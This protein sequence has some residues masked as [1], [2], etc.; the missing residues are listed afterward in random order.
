MESEVHL[1]GTLVAS[2]IALICDNRRTKNSEIKVVP[3]IQPKK[4]IY[5]NTIGLTIY[6]K[7]GFVNLNW[8]IRNTP[9]NMGML[10]QAFNS[11]TREAEAVADGSL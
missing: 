10:A 1:Q 6:P 2:V 9:L 5:L 4:L 3:Y 11:S 8:N 7:S